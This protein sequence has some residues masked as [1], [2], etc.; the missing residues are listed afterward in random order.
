MRRPRV[1]SRYVVCMFLAANYHVDAKGL[2]SSGHFFFSRLYGCSV[3]K[4]HL[5]FGFTA[6]F[7]SPVKDK[8][9]FMELAREGTAADSVNA[10]EIRV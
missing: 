2:D 3:L 4:L 8:V 10:N 7:I 9:S 1:Y 6:I 5:T